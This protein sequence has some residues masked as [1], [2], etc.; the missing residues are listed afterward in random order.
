MNQSTTQWM[1]DILKKTNG[2]KLECLEISGTDWKETFENHNYTSTQYPSF[3][4]TQVK[5]FSKQYDIII[6][7]Q[8][9]EHLELPYTALRNVY[10]LLKPNGYVLLTV[11]FLIQIHTAPG[12]GD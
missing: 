5:D 2:V 1:S 9:W 7:E 3:D 6:A 4:I 10:Q 12:F 8:V 11:P